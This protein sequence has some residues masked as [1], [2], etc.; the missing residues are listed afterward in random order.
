MESGWRG[1]EMEVGNRDGD[2]LFEDIDGNC[3]RKG[4]CKWTHDGEV[5]CRAFGKGGGGLGSLFAGVK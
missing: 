4:R 3:K 1:R 2:Y 5:L